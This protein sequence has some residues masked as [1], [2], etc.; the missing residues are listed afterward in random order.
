MRV[1]KKQHNLSFGNSNLPM[2]INYCPK[3]RPEKLLARGVDVTLTLP[4]PCVIL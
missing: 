3:Y 4:F 2:E 1:L